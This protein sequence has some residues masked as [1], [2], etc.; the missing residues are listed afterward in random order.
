MGLARSHLAAP[1]HNL[2]ALTASNTAPV[3][4]VERN[5]PGSVMA[6]PSGSIAGDIRPLDVDKSTRLARYE[7][8]VANDSLSPVVAF[9]YSISTEPGSTSDACTVSSFTIAPYTAVAS[10]IFVQLPARG[11]DPRVVVE[12]LADTAHLTLDA[13]APRTRPSWGR[14]SGSALPAAIALVALLALAYIPN[15]TSILALI[16][17]QHVFAGQAFEVA[18]AARSAQRVDY[19]IRNVNGT[20]VSQG[21]LGS[22]PSGSISLTLPR[23]LQATSYNVTLQAHGVLENDVRSLHVVALAP[24]SLAHRSHA[25]PTIAHVDRITLGKDAIISGKPIVV[26]YHVAAER[27]MIQ[28]LDQT[29]TVRASVPMQ[30]SNGNG[31]STLIAPISADDQEYQLIAHAELGQTV[32]EQ[33][34]GIMIHGDPAL[35]AASGLVAPNVAIA[36]AVDSAQGTEGNSNSVQ[37]TNLQGGHSTIESVSP[38]VNPPFKLLQEN[39]VS[40]DLIHVAILNDEPRFRLALTAPSGDAISE[41]TLKPGQT[42]ALFRAPIV[43]APTIYQMLGSFGLGVTQDTFIRSILIRPNTNGLRSAP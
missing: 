31:T 37:I 34:I 43:S 1:R 18:Y 19:V 24:P 27:G 17:P 14:L 38:T 13:G 29:G 5:G 25:R 16:G 4:A 23:T 28:I 6:L 12:I 39:A 41:V 40:G 8:L 11:N 20:L 10:E 35:A 7:V 22:S 26:Q 21:A 36:Q 30:L 42:L 15:R 33:S 2:P 32:A 9:A 3:P